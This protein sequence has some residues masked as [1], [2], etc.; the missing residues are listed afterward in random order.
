VHLAFH[1]CDLHAELQSYAIAFSLGMLEEMGQPVRELV[2]A[3]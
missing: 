2:R 1:Q 3:V